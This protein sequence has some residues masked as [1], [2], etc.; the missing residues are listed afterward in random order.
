ML[1]LAVPGYIL[2][3]VTTSVFGVAGPVQERWRDQFGSD[4][5]FPEV[6]S[7]PGAI[8]TLSLTLYPYVYLLARAALRD[9]TADAYFVARTL[10]ASPGE[11]TRRVV[12]PM[13]RPAIAAGAAV[14]VMETLTDFATVQYFGVDTVSVGVFRIWRGTYDRD[15][16][17]ELATLVLVFAAAGHRARTDPARPGPLRPRPAARAPASRR[18]CCAGWRA[19][20]ATVASAPSSCWPGSAPRRRSSLAWA[21]REQRGDRGTPLRR[22]LPR[23]P[24]QQPRAD[25]R[26]RSPSASSSPWSSPTPAASPTRGSSAPANRLTAVGYA[27]P[28]PVVAMGVILAVVALDD[29]LGG[30]GLGLPGAVAT[31][32]FIALVYAYGV[33]FIGPGLTTV[34]SGLGQVS[35]EVT[36]SA[37]SLGA[38]PLAV[39]RPDPPP[40]VHAPASSPPP[41]S[42]ASTPQGA[43]DRPA[44]AP[45]RL[46]H[47]AGL[48]L[49]PG[50]GDRASSRP[51]SRR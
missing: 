21:I 20:A 2:G 15:A 26:R 29:L 12:F 34:E 47:V 30:V 4:A 25:R 49:Q 38:R 40:A 7:M 19:V 3:F 42:S 27:V 14:V 5:W 6:R 51:R 41:C 48:G 17:A 28:G 24:R 10:G 43:A 1:P 32:S 35:D 16:A 9:Q 37:R 50:L 39:A 22:P 31:G 8:V 18:G 36:A 44:A 33:R 23:L 45:D 13:L 46:R 11:A